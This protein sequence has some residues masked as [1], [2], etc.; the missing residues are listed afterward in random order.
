VRR[1]LPV[2]IPGA[3]HY[4]FPHPVGNS[5]KRPSPILNIC[6]MVFVHAFP[7]LPFGPSLRYDP[8]IRAAEKALDIQNVFAVIAPVRPGEANVQKEVIGREQA[9]ISA[10]WHYQLC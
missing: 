10:Q 4:A 1:L 5:P 7:L 3:K 2:A 6:A 9:P 8:Y